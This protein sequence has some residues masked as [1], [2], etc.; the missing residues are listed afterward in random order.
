MPLLSSL[1]FAQLVGSSPPLPSAW[2][3]ESPHI[4][5]ARPN[6]HSPG[7][8][9]AN[10]AP[11]VGLA[12]VA[13]DVGYCRKRQ[14]NL[15]TY[16]MQHHSPMRTV[17]AL[18]T[19]TSRW[20]SP[21]K[22][23]LRASWPPPSNAFPAAAAR[24]IAPLPALRDVSPASSPSPSPS[25][26]A[27]SPLPDPDRALTPMPLLVS[28]LR[29]SLEKVRAASKRSSASHKQAG[30]QRQQAQDYGPGRQQHRCD[31]S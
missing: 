16:L 4:L 21:P 8:L 7:V 14:D 11:D 30:S 25:P 3:L 5:P 18:A 17:P 26:F 22:D 9:L 1:G 12:N 15:H 28:K 2:Q 29:D 20:G 19:T 23:P 31:G 10:V 6:L 13:P 27:T 24:A